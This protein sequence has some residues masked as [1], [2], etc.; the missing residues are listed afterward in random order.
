MLKQ[1][2]NEGFLAFY[3]RWREKAAHLAQRP[4][5]LELVQKFIDNCHEKYNKHLRYLGLDTFQKVYSVATRIEDDLAKE[6]ANKPHYHHQPKYNYKKWNDNS[7]SFITYLRLP[8]NTIT[9][10]NIMI[11]GKDGQ[12]KENLLHFL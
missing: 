8:R 7:S 10:I 12:E 1:G 6:K 9:Q 5:E 4:P 11:L 2:D 3:G